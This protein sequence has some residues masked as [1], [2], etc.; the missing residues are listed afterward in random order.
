MKRSLSS[1]YTYGRCGMNEYCPLLVGYLI[2][3]VTS[4]GLTAKSQRDL[5]P[6][7]LLEGHHLHNSRVVTFTWSVILIVPKLYKSYSPTG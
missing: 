6:G 3:I 5:E 1:R 4:V 7:S 2:H